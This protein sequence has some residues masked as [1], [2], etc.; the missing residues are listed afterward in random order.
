MKHDGAQTPTPFDPIAWIRLC[1]G[2]RVFRHDRDEGS[3]VYCSARSSNEKCVL[4]RIR[5]LSFKSTWNDLPDHYPSVEC[6][7]FVVMPIMFTESSILA[8]DGADGDSDVGAGLKPAR[9]RGG[10]RIRSGLGLKPVPTLPEIIRAFKTFSARRINEMRNTGGVPLWQRNYYEHVVRGEN[11]LRSHSRI[12]RE[13][14]LAVGNG[15]GESKS[16][17]CEIDRKSANRGKYD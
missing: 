17:R 6:D 2:W 7:A 16:H 12:H 9:G 14:S 13:Q 5:S 8:E 11:E 1:A 15:S 10:G 3:Y 4:N